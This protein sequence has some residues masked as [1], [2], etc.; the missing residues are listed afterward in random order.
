MT[1]RSNYTMP[2]PASQP[3]LLNRSFG[4]ETLNRSFCNEPVNR[5]FGNEHLNRSFGDF[6]RLIDYNCPNSGLDANQ[7]YYDNDYPYF[8]AEQPSNFNRSFSEN[9]NLSIAE[10]TKS[11]AQDRKENIYIN[12]LRID[13]VLKIFFN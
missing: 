9:L 12:K 8:E 5:S 11:W 2:R 10:S 3:S 4:N 6:N 7:P 13:Q 1:N